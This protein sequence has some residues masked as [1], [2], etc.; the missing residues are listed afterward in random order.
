[1]RFFG[2]FIIRWKRLQQ[3]H[4]RIADLKAENADLRAQIGRQ[5]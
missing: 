5:E 1:M 4:K 2:F 3:M